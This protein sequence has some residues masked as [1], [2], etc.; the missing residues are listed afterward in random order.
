MTSNTISVSLKVAFT[1]IAEA[2]LQ[3]LA[4]YGLILTQGQSITRTKS[5]WKSSEDS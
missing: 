1:H 4:W 2:S 3:V 5:A